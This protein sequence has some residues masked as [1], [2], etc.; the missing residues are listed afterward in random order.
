MVDLI[1]PVNLPRVHPAAQENTD[2]GVETQG[3]LCQTLKRRQAG[4]VY[5]AHS[6]R[7]FHHTQAILRKGLSVMLRAHLHAIQG[8]CSPRGGVLPHLALPQQ[9]L[10]WNWCL[11]R[12]L[13]DPP[14]VK[15]DAR[16]ATE[17]I[18]P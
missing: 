10:T 16:Q 8:T 11:E 7:N 17:G 18:P 3:R 13:L 1:I 5:H 9:M 2:Q 4:P 6:N 12:Y 14:H 15:P